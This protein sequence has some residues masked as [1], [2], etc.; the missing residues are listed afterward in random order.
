MTGLDTLRSRYPIPTE[1]P[2]VP[3]DYVKGEPMGWCAGENRA[4][5]AKLCNPDTRVV[6]DGGSFLGLSAWWFLKTAPNATVICIDHWKGSREHLHRPALAA[7]L[8]ILYETFLRN[9]WEW[10]DRIVPIRSDSVEG[11]REVAAL[12]VVPDVVY[13]DWSHDADNVCRDLTAAMDLFPPPS[14]I[15]GDDWTWPT[16]REGALRAVDPRGFSLDTSRTCYRI[17][18]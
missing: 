13:V 15:I 16:V 12:G 14:E 18:R 8:P 2:N 1:M 5:F 9:L 17:I 7:K 4:L 11:M 6:I 3:T 10:R